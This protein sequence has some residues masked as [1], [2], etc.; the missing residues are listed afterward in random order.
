MFRNFLKTAIRNLAKHKFYSFINITGLAIGIACCMIIVIFVQHELSYDKHHKKADRIYRVA[1]DIEFGGNH[2]RLAVAPAPMAEALKNDF[3]EVEEVVRFRSRGTYLVKRTEENF[4]ENNVIF[5]DASVFD[6]FTL[7]MLYGEPSSALVEPNTV[8]ITKSMAKKYFDKED[9]VGETLIFDDELECKITGVIEDM[10]SNGH[11][12]FNFL[13]SMENLDESK[14]QI[15]L[16]NNFQTYVTL[17]EGTTPKQLE[18]KFPL[19]IEKY[20]GPQAK[21]V[22]DIDFEQ[23]LEAG[24]SLYYYLQPLT[25]IHLHSDLTAELEA[26]GSIIYVYIFSSI[27]F[28]ILV[29]ACI[30]FMN[31][32]TARSAN[33]AKEVGVRKA[34]GSYKSQLVRQFLTESMVMSVLALL[35]AIVLVE[36]ALPFFNDIAGRELKSD[37]FETGTITVTVIFITLFVGLISGAYPAFFLSAFNPAN[38]LKGRLQ[39]G[40]KSGTL[41]SV[42]VV[43]QFSISIILIIGTVVIFNQLNYIQGKK[44]GFNKEQVLVVHD[45]YALGDQLN[46]FKNEIEN[47]HEI[48]SSTVSGFLPVANTNRSDMS[49]WPEG[50]MNEDNSV[51]MQTWNVDHDYIQTLGMEIVL[52]RNFSEDI[53]SDSNAVIINETAAKN[54]GYENPLN[55][56][57]QSPNVL[58]DG[59]PDPNNKHVYKIIGVVKNFHFESL[60]DNIGALGFF[61]KR[62]RSF[63]SVRFETED[64]GTT[65]KTIEAK[66]KEIA[67]G[68]PFSYSFLDQRFNQIYESEN[69]LGK[70]FTIFASLA[71]FIACLGLFGLASF[72]SEQRTKEIGI[73]KV[74]GATVWDVILLLSKEFSKLVLIAFALALP[75]AY[76]LKNWL[77][78]DYAFKTNIGIGTFIFVGMFSFLMA[79]LTMSYQSIKAARI[80]PT[81]SLKYE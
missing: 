80:N 1:S 10:P 28:F 74:L 77:L 48:L 65:L 52:G 59:N 33:R 22:L 30:N 24:N 12:H 14:N 6:V 16:S 11:F 47:H 40:I 44:L 58:E 75:A 69:R 2:F 15:W 37:Y 76:F 50:A 79:W 43:F 63:I 49:F 8:V 60:R 57:I 67:P 42:L 70:I 72:T 36:F 31:L 51:S 32:S 34:M 45:A 55:H 18:E 81:E 3:P 20:V 38:V 17:N 26:N 62:S 73:R 4:K 54:L 9:V 68:Q 56:T 25:D 27:A 5:A 64:V 53:L 35:L 7:P 78:Q 61:L 23:F 41:R 13:L 66:W 29:I 19:M 21:N 46:S 71:I 39:S